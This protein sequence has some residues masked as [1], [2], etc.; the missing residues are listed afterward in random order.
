MYQ[1]RRLRGTQRGPATCL[2]G[3][4]TQL[5]GPQRHRQLSEPQRQGLQG[6]AR[7]H[8]TN[9]HKGSSDTAQ[10]LQRP[11]RQSLPERLRG[12]QRHNACED[13]NVSVTATPV[14]TNDDC[15][16]AM[17]QRLRGPM[18]ASMLT[19][20]GPQRHK[21]LRGPFGGPAG[22]RGWR[23]LASTKAG[24]RDAMSN[25]RPRFRCERSPR[26]ALNARAIDRAQGS[27]THRTGGSAS[28]ASA[29]EQRGAANCP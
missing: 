13:R 16:G 17:A 6:V 29:A 7:L 2:H 12:P 1:R 26:G 24:Q 19:V 14:T 25:T 28:R 15:E 5:R 23:R 10:R 4:E 11:Q 3:H 8:G 22:C 27:S 21:R 18:S 20:R 9:V